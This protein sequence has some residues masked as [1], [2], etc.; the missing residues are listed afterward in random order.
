MIVD[1]EGQI[2][3]V[4]GMD[5]RES[6]HQKSSKTLAEKSEELTGNTP[7]MEEDFDEIVDFDMI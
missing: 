7:K 1:L 4:T 5:M 3:A 6:D 2:A